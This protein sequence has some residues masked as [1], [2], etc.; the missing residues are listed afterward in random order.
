MA[1][2]V[3]Q[4]ASVSPIEAIE[5]ET[6]SRVARR[7]IP[8]LMVSYFAA[9]LD[10]VNV[11]FAALTMNK[12]LGFSA[13][14][15]GIGSGIFFFGYFL[16]E[17]PSNL[18]LSKVG[19]RKWI[20]RILITWGVISGATAFV[21]G[22]WSFLGIRFVLG[23]A[24]AGFYPGIILYLTWWFPSAYRSRI[25]GIFMT[26]IPIS[27]VTGSLV[28]SQILRLGN[29]GGLH[30]WQWLFILEAIPAVILGFVVMFYLTDGPEHAHWL[31]PEQRQWL[32]ARLA[33]ERS[34][35]ESIRHYSLKETMLNPRVWLLT[36]VYFGQNMTGYGVVLFLPQIVSRFGVGVGMNG[37]I[38]ALPFVAGAIAMVLWGM[39]SDRTGERPLHAAGACFLTFAALSVCVLLDSPVL[40]MIAIIVSQ[41][42]QSSIAPT[43][44]T[45][46]TAMLSGTAAAGGI[47]LINAVGN[48]GGFLGP[49]M[50]GAIKDA[51]GSFSIGLLSIA[52]GALV[53][54][55]VLVVLGH[56][57]HLEKAPESSGDAYRVAE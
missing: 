45:L 30:D 18:I 6:M 20:A 27:I 37:L 47:A 2:T 44:W 54:S 7:L 38:S 3:A 5:K 34:H 26:A 14:V 35:K 57:R 46:P 19:A 39:H 56:D 51:T 50:M 21:T 28:S 40:T 53:A 52:T 10:R 25:I 55:I 23:L 33:R 12:A 32:M 16:F 48:L 8:L 22:T 15:F 4:S 41:M 9:Y 1:S 17:V 11:G 36:L 49:Y 43:F 24:E 13:E 29:W 31:R 42:G